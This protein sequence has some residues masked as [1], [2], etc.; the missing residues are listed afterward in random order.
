MASNKNNPV[1]EDVLEEIGID[2][3]SI[4]EHN[5]VP[6]HRLINAEE[7]Q[8]LL[9]KYNVKL[10]QLPRINIKDPVVKTISGI[11]VGDI[12]EIKRKSVTAGESLYYRVVTK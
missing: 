8:E 3:K 4:T 2:K 12:V 1:R 10:K 7:K 6:K 9:N 5:L 11:K